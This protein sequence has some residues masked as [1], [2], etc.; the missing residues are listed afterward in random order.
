MT[1]VM[2]APF[3]PHP[4]LLPAERRWHQAP[5][6]RVA[7]ACRKQARTKE[8]RYE[9]PPRKERGPTGGKERAIGKGSADK[10]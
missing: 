5:A 6:R 10:G 3:G 7:V 2:V 8:R 9:T 4:N 1:V